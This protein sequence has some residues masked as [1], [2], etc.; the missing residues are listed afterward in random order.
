MRLPDRSCRLALAEV[1]NW[2]EVEGWSG[3]EID[4]LEATWLSDVK[5]TMFDFDE[6]KFIHCF[7]LELGLFSSR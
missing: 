7:I 5:L 1:L 2:A 6:G 3:A 4:N